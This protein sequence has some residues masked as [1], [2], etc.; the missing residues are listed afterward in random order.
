MTSTAEA[1][2]QRRLEDYIRLANQG[3]SVRLKVELLRL[4]IRQRLHPQESADTGDEIRM[5]LLMA[6]YTLTVGD[7]TRR[8]SKVYAIG[9]EEEPP[10]KAKVNMR[11]ATERLMMDYHRLKSA[12]ITFEERYF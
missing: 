8:V 4:P 9:S 11:I 12:G 6:D 7:E 1:Q 3:N 5:Y 2:P 10:D